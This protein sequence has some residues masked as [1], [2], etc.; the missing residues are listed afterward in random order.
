MLGWRMIRYRTIFTVLCVLCAQKFVE[1]FLGYDANRKSI[2]VH[3]LL[4]SSYPAKMI[5]RWNMTNLGAGNRLALA[6]GL[7]DWCK[8]LCC[9]LFSNIR[10]ILRIFTNLRKI[11][12]TVIIGDNEGTSFYPQYMPSFSRGFLLYVLVTKFV[13]V[14]ESSLLNSPICARYRVL[15]TK[16]TA[17]PPRVIYFS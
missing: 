12:R 9:T 8:V 5:D 15:V 7:R 3:Q 16:K 13:R 11:L 10:K 6:A 2:T 14:I 17:S 4:M 1:F